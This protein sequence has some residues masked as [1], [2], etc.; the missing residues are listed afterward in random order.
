[1]ILDLYYQKIIDLI[2]KHEPRIHRDW[3]K[4]VT[5]APTR[6]GLDTIVEIS[7]PVEI[8]EQVLQIGFGKMN[9]VFE[10][11]KIVARFGNI[12]IRF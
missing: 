7:I 3:I 1:M 12:R 11:K 6:Q 4:S 2:L 10:H 9:A 8:P 5:L